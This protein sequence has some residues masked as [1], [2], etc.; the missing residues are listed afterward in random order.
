MAVECAIKDDLLMI[1][2]EATTTAKINY[3]KIA[4]EVLTDIG[5]SNKFKIIKTI[6]EQSPEINRAVTG[7][8]ELTANDQGIV[9]G[10]ACKDTPELMPMPIS[11]A[12]RLMQRYNA[13]QNKKDRR[14]TSNHY[15]PDAKCQVSIEYE[16]NKP[17]AVHTILVSASHDKKVSNDEIKATI[18]EEIIYPLLDEFSSLVNTK[19]CKII[20]N[21][22]GAFTIWG[23][24]SDSGCVGRKIIVDTYGGIG[25]HG[26]GAFSSKNATKVDRSG[27]YYARYVAKNIVAAGLADKCEVQVAYAIGVAEPIKVDIDCF[28]TNTI[29]TKEIYKIIENNFDFRPSNMIAELGLLNPIYKAT[30]C[31]GHFGRN[32]FPWEKVKKLAGMP[33]V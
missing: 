2:G 13:W 26:G 18:T 16:N 31:Y 9:Y 10:F 29:S 23:S 20:I 24:F 21:P 28:G 19:D 22:S 3:E 14:A 11:M 33:H 15:F 8:A 5:Y 7:S 1:Y 12:H 27:A 25:R 32:E 6:S 4:R 17:L 30:A